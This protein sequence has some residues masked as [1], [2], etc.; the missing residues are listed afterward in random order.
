MQKIDFD[1]ELIIHDDAS[2]DGTIGT[3]RE[4]EAKYPEQI[5]LVLEKTNQ[6]VKNT[7]E[8]VNDLLKSAKGK[9]IACCEGDDY[10]TDPH[11]LQQQVDFLDA[12]PD[13]SLVFHPAEVLDEASG[14]KS[15][16]PAES[17]DFDLNGL[18][19][20]NFIATCSVMYRRQNYDGL[21]IAVM[22]QD[23]YFHLY[24]AQFGKIGFI[25]KPMSVYRRHAGGVW[26]ESD[27]NRQKF[28]KQHG[29]AHLRFHDAVMGMFGDRAEYR[30]IIVNNGADVI[31]EIQNADRELFLKSISE[32]REFA[33]AYIDRLADRLDKLEEHSRAQTER[34]DKVQIELELSKQEAELLRS[35]LE[36]TV[37]H[38][39]KKI[40]KRK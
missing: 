37:T 5:K 26:W 13:H 1:F 9:Y 11:K 33:A 14:D 27:K 4:Y 28:W 15:V 6:Y 30:K 38:R 29:P 23:W 21:L 3:L 36:K 32:Y 22:P 17:G 25:D 16:Y 31:K 7:F 35:A 2:T 12:H 24:H 8:F 34:I 39:I 18:L 19:V 20:R 40:V 10:W